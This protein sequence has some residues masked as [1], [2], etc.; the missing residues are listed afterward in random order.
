MNSCLAAS[1]FAE[2]A[3]HVVAVGGSPQLNNTLCADVFVAAPEK[4]KL[5]KAVTANGAFLV[6]VIGRLCGLTAQSSL[7]SVAT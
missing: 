1:S 3:G 5:R 4:V 7:A 6:I 2:R